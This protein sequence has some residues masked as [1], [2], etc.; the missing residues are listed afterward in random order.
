MLYSTLA[1]KLRQYD[2]QAPKLK[3][4]ALKTLWNRKAE[5]LCPDFISF[6]LVYSSV[7]R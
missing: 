2:I 5:A 1:Y 4:H 3:D 7:T 6:I